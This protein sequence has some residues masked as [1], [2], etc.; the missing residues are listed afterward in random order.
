MLFTTIMSTKYYL[1]SIRLLLLHIYADAKY[2]NENS[3]QIS[4][5]A[6]NLF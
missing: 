2:G 3:G 1:F 6:L 4:I 5:Y